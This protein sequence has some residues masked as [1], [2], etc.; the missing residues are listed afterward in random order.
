MNQIK[1]TSIENAT[2]N[3]IKEHIYSLRN[4][5]NRN[6]GRAEEHLSTKDV[7]KYAD[8][9]PA[10][11]TLDIIATQENLDVNADARRLIRAAVKIKGHR[12]GI[13][14]DKNNIFQ[15]KD[16]DEVKALEQSIK[17]HSDYIEA[18]ADEI[19]AIFNNK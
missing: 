8:W 9:N 16:A 19:V 10:I 18:A 14:S 15:N 6:L 7:V 11:E 4:E 1:R 5:K 13:I 3:L 12:M 17:V 2:I